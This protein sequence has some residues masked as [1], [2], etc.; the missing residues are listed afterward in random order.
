MSHEKALARLEQHP[1]LIGYLF[2]MGI[3]LSQAG[4][5]AANAGSTNG[6]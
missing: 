3:V 1:R 2:T 5:V 6:P 4:N